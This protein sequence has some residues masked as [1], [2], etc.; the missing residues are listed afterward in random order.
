MRRIVFLLFPIAIVGVLVYL[1]T[2]IPS[3]PERVASHFGASGMANGYMSRDGYR[4]FIIAFAVGAPLF[5]VAVVGLLPRAFPGAINL[6]DRD[7]WLAP[8]RRDDTLGYLFGWACSLGSLLALFIAAIHS[9]VMVAN[10]YEP[11]RLP[12]TLFVILLVA[13]GVG[14]LVWVVALMS[15]FRRRT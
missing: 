8:E 14:M 3:L 7:Y 1:L 4:I 5:V 10:A 12:G 9:A 13:F 6:P 15:H 2:T 11:P